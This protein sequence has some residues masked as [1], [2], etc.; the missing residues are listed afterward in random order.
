M[1]SS[2]LTFLLCI[3]NALLNRVLPPLTQ[4][5]TSAMPVLNSAKL[6]CFSYR[7][8]MPHPSSFL[9]FLLILFDLRERGR[10]GGGG[11]REK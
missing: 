7:L 5:P 4:P 9:F 3:T 11:E 10:E 1:L 6:V 8:F 2:H